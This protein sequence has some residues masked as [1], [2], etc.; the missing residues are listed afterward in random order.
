MSEKDTV[1]KD[2]LS[3]NRRFADLCNY[4]LFDG[5][6][7][8][9]PESLQEQ[10]TTELI[11]AL[12]TAEKTFGIADKAL[13]VQ[14]W[15][16]I[17]K[18]TVIKRSSDHIYVVIGVENQTDIHYAMPVRNMLYDA[19]NYSGQVSEAARQHRQNR[20]YSNSAEFLSG[21]T[22]TDKLTPVITIAVYWGD[23]IWDAPRSLH[24]MLKTDDAKILNFVSDYKLQLIAPNEITDFNKFKTNLGIVLETIK[25]SSDEAA[26]DKLINST[27]AFASLDMEAANAINIFTNLNLSFDKKEATANMCKAWEDHKLSG[28]REGKIKG[29]IEGSTSK[30]I[31]QTI[32]KINK[33]FSAEETADMLEEP[34]DT[35]QR[36]YD[37]AASMEP[38]YD[39]EKIYEELQ[40]SLASIC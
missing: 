15:R 9:Q 34:I 39:I 3:D 27:P 16:G 30:L 32:K 21:F 2:F 24:D 22:Q 29:K 8:I 26:M 25:F 13:N 6:Q 19:L 10:D 1:A 18:R 14:K 11:S 5:H 36:I 35:I 33:G 28:I 23:D 4:Y 38:D 20:D 37:I 17:L 40:K 12:D 31:E 7:V